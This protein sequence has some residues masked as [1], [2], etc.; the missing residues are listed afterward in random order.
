MQF[1]LPTALEAL[2]ECVSIFRNTAFISSKC[3]GKKVTS[4]SVVDLA[5]NS[6]IWLGCMHTV[7]VDNRSPLAVQC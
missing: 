6:G 7:L 2:M 1:L 4:S 3:F 5:V